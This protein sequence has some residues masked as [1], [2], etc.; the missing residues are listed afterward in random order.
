MVAQGSAG[1][2]LEVAVYAAAIVFFFV[3]VALF[4]RGRGR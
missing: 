3:L 1:G 4:L 2:G